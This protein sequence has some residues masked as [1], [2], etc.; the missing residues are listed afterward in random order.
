MVCQ[1]FSNDFMA[2]YLKTL[3]QLVQRVLYIF[4]FYLE[5]RFTKFDSMLFDFF[6]H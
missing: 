2:F 6:F 4:R 5:F 3:G 1:N